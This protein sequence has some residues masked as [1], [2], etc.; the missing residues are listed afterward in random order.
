MEAAQSPSGVAIGD[1]RLRDVEKQSV[2]GEFIGA[3]QI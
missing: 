2:L 3:E 1:A